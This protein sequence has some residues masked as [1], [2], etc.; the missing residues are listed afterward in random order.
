MFAS[1]LGNV[2]NW[3]TSKVQFIHTFIFFT[4]GS[5]I[6][7]I[8]NSGKPLTCDHQTTEAS[9]ETIEGKVYIF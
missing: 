9:K 6:Y 8:H 5:I 3:F 4:I 1:G 2:K 7:V